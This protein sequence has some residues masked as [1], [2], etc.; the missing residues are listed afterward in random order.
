MQPVFNEFE[1]VANAATVDSHPMEPFNP[2]PVEAIFFERA[3]AE[4]EAFGCLLF[5]N[6]EKHDNSAIP[7]S[8]IQTSKTVEKI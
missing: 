1:I 6:E 7:N 5:A 8:K 2:L 4:I 3:A